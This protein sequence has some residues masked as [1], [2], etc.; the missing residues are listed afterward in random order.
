[1]SGYAIAALVLIAIGLTGAAVAIIA[2]SAAIIAHPRDYDR[3]RNAERY[4]GPAL[5]GFVATILA[6]LG[7]IFTLTAWIVSLLV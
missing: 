6:A 7:L 4:V 2:G 3:M 5:A 1:M